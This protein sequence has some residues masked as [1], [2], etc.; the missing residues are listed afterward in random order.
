MKKGVL[1]AFIGYVLLLSSIPSLFLLLF[2]LGGIF[3]LYVLT[4]IYGGRGSLQETA[5]IWFM[6]HILWGIVYVFHTYHFSFSPLFFVLLTIITGK[7]LHDKIQTTHTLTKGVALSSLILY[8][9]FVYIF[10]VA[11]IT[12]SF[13]YA[14]LLVI[15]F[16]NR[17]KLSREAFVLLYRSTWGI[18]LMDTLAHRYPRIL[19]FFGR[20]SIVL[21]FVGMI[22]ITG[23]VFYNVFQLLFVA[24]TVPGISPLLPG[25]QLPGSPI[26]LPLMYGI[27]SLFFVVVLHEFFH[28]VLAR[29]YAIPVKSSGL[30]LFGP[31]LG[32][33]VEPDETI[34]RKKTAPIQ[35]SIFSVGPCSNIVAAVLILFVLLFALAPLRETFFSF[36]PLEIKSVRD[37]GPAAKAGITADSLIFFID[38]RN[39][40]TVEEFT[41]FMTNATPG[42]ALEIVTNKGKFTVYPEKEEHRVV[43]GVTLQKSLLLKET[44]LGSLPWVLIYL[45][46]LLSW[47]IVISIGIGIANLLPLGPVDG[48]R[49]LQVGLTFLFTK[50]ES[51]WIWQWIG[52]SLFL[53]ILFILLFP[54]FTWIFP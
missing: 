26:T 28:G 16:L 53:A 51:E 4:R 18:S 29:V 36:A 39:I 25:V 23:Y 38:G 41:S 30:V 17:H 27:I 43:L 13:F 40:T 24:N 10:A 33:F 50:K 19:R 11:E 44:G 15:I 37:Q 12:T 46:Q 47:F 22:F 3:L 32:A 7:I 31:L 20:A 42:K 49:M 14:S 6:S 34:L 48:G 52:T 5:E 9:V 21:G 8:V 54:F 45:E 1:G 2:P 35:L